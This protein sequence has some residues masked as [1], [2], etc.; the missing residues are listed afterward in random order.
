[1]GRVRAACDPAMMVALLL[2]SYVVGLRSARQIER[3]CGGDV[4]FKVITAMRVP[5]HSTVAEF[6][7]R[8]EQ[9]IGELFVAVLALCGEAGLVHAV[10]PRARAFRRCMARCGW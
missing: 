7:R 4:A 3:A 5:D 1:M 10:V 9:A 8:H 2:Y 6:R